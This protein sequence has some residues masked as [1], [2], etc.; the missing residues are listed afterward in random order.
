MQRLYQYVISLYKI[1]LLMPKI[2]AGRIPQI[3]TFFIFD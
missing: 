1:R 2:D 3:V